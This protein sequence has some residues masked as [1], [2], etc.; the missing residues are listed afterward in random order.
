MPQKASIHQLYV[1]SACED[2]SI[3]RLCLPVSLSPEDLDKVGHLME[4]QGPF[5]K[6]DYIYR[7]GDKFKYIYAIEEGAVKTYGITRDGREQVT[8]FH[9]SGEMLGIDAI[10][11]DMHPCNAVALE[12][13]R[14]CAF[15]FNKL[16]RLAQEIPG[17]Q[18]EL[19]R[20]LSRELLREERMMMTLGATSAEQRIARFLYNMY[21]RKAERGMRDDMLEL[22]ATRQDIGNYLGLAVETVSRQLA[23]MQESGIIDVKSRMIHVRDLEALKNQAE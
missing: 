22:C 20:I 9:L 8:G 6:G 21:Q 10:D 19:T 13:S 2:C 12:H 3:R 16:E 14:V 15:P 11:S 5:K 23:H 4:H 1:K 17:L 7:T 18:R